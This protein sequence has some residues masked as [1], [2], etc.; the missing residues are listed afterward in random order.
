LSNTDP[1][2]AP[3]LYS[4]K[5]EWV[6]VEGKI[7]RVGISQYAQVGSVYIHVLFSK[8]PLPFF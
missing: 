1:A 5:H 8:S 4:E 6:S 7:G 2:A 3:R